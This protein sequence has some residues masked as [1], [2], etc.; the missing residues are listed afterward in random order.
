MKIVERVKAFLNVGSRTAFSM[1]ADTGNVYAAWNGN[2]YDSD[3]V[4]A[5]IRP[6]AKAIGKLT[7]KHV[8][9]F[10]GKVDVNPEPYIRFL[11][12]EPNPYMGGHALL[13]KLA[14]QLALNNNAFLLIVRDENGL[15]QQLYPIP[16][17]LAESVYIGERLYLK[18]T[19]R[20]GKISTFP[21]EEIVHIRNDFNENDIFGTS[22]APAL[23]QLMEIVNT[24]DQGIVKA[25][26][27]SGVIRWLLK[28]STPMRA[29]D[30][31][32]NV[33]EFVDNYLSVSSS[34]FGAAGVD[35]K[36]D[37]IRIEPKDYV[38]NAL[39]MSSTE[40]RIY[41]FFNTNE[42]IVSSAY[43][44]DE[45]NSYFE[46]VIEP[47]AI[48][49]AEEFT[50]KLFTRKER[51]FGNRIYF[52]AANLQCASLSTKLALQAMVDRG[53]L[54]PNEWRDTFNLSPVKNGDKPLR[55]LDT[56]TVDGVKAL[57]DSMTLENI[58]ETKEKILEKLKGGGTSESD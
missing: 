18:F 23:S 38:P 58:A 40:K 9:R 48:Q 46:I 19:F 45:W 43:T 32:K 15:P 56:Q 33:Q 35:A 10:G 47:V 54:T 55:R 12:E 6:Y 14:T 5:C 37:A 2:I 21:Y 34:T 44:E 17:V 31:K 52:D 26:R 16:A 24:T 36:A 25:I 51:G 20:N 13:E 8:R 27:N 42:K 1:I 49:L 30:L 4:R 7:A 3:I 53:A 57:L 11:L 28:Y 50:R 41:S 39:Q 22:P 29:E